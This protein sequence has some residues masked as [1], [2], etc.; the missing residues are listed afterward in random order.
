MSVPSQTSSQM[1]QHLTNDQ[2]E[3]NNFFW[4][5]SD[6]QCVAAVKFYEATRE[7]L[8]Y[9]FIDGGKTNIFIR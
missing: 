7:E 1:C 5:P 2:Y 4:D 6:T 3:K 9:S 8:E